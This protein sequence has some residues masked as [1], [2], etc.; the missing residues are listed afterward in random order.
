[1]KLAVTGKGGV[2]KTTVAAGL[3]RLFAREGYPVIT[4]DADPDANLAAA[5]GIDPEVAARIVPI[6][7]MSDLIAERTGSKAGTIGG[8]FKLNPRVDDLPDDFSVKVNGVKHLVLGTVEKGGSGCICP[9]S[10]MLKALMK[11][12]I[13]RRDEVVIMDMEAGIEH[14]GRGTAASV[15]AMLV[16]VEPGQ[17][18]VQ[19]ARQIQKLA[20]DLN[21]LRVFLVLNKVH[22][23][24]EERQLR[25]YLPELPVIGTVRERESIRKADLEGRSPFDVDPAFVA[26]IAVIKERLEKEIGASADAPAN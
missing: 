1:V 25:A 2:G 15:D 24:E 18:S 11:H 21:L 10:T 4:I 19:T 8:I 17:R 23:G 13:V 20:A 5:L 3:A 16:V 22:D 26:E 6:A 7:K 9:E 14:L 12:V